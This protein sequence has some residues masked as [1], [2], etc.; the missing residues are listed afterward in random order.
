MAPPPMANR[1]RVEGIAQLCKVVQRR[2]VLVACRHA[3]ANL[4]RRQPGAIRPRPR[5]CWAAPGVT[6]RQGI[7][8]SVLPRVLY[9]ESARS[10]AACRTSY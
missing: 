10:A 7:A 4:G 2:A 5:W 1:E 6:T 8:H 9:V 3:A